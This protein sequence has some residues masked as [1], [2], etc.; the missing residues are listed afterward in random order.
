MCAM[1]IFPLDITRF[2]D[3]IT[4]YLLRWKRHYTQAEL[5]NLSDETLE[6]IG[7]EPSRRDFDTVK[8][9]WMP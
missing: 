6:D 8:P 7:L 2:P 1:S 5:E 4:V 9:F 3:F